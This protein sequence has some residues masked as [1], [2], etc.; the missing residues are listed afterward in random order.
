MVVWL[1]APVARCSFQA[2]RDTPIGEVESD[3]PSD[4]DAKRVEEGRGFFE[5]LGSEAKVCY[6]RTPL[7]GQESWKSGLLLGFAALT[8]LGWLIGKWEKRRKGTFADRR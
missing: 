8:A 2:F 1:M 6:R 3:Q 5:R 7:F 4:S